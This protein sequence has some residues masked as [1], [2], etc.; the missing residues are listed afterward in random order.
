MET[1]LES[2]MFY[3]TFSVINTM[4][5]PCTALLYDSAAATWTLNCPQLY[6]A[7]LVKSIWF[8]FWWC[9]LL[10]VDCFYKLSL[11]GPLPPQNKVRRVEI[12][13]IGW[14]GVMDLMRNESVPLEVMP[15][16]FNYFVWQIRWPPLLEQST[17]IPQAYLPM[18][19]THFTLS[20]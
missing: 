7:F 8:L 12:L 16:V 14:P 3:Y 11:S 9:P 20:W 6:W 1:N 19:Q 15:G 10:S 17:W 13:G 4:F 2:I 18:G 5:V